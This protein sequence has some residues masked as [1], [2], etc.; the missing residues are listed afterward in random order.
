[1]GDLNEQLQGG[2]P[3]RTGKWT[4]GPESPNS[5]K[6]IEFM[7]L[8]SLTAINTTFQPRRKSDLHT[9]R[10]TKRSGQA[11]HSDLGEH[12]GAPVKSRYKK[13]WI[14]GVV[15]ATQQINGTQTWTIRYKDG[16][17][18][19]CKTSNWKNASARGER[20]S[21]PPTRLCSSFYKM[22][23]MCDEM[24]DML[25]TGDTQGPSWRT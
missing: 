1:M 6:F 8:H 9:F 14:E 11:A 13:K 25:G 7:Q 23:I 12:V 19:H 2:V 22:E 15:V 24:Q 18:H 21:R 4:G 17:T 5:D 3:N 16:Y 20:K 10:Q